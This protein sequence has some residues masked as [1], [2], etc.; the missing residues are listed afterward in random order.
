M[1]HIMSL[2]GRVAVRRAR[3]AALLCV[4]FLIV[5]EW[6]M[7]VE[8]AAAGPQGC[9]PE[10]SC[11]NQLSK[12]VC[13]RRGLIRV[14]PGIPSNTRHLNLMENSIEAIQADSFRNLHHLEVLQLGRNAIRQIE[15][16][17]FNG[18]TSLNT[19]ELFDNRLTVV[20]SGA[21]E[22][23]SKLRELWLRN[24]PIESIPSYAFNR[25]PSLMRLD[26]GELRKLEYISDGAFEGLH[27]LKYLNLGMC[28]IRGEMPNLSPLLGLEELEISENLFPE[29]KPGSF[30]GLRS[31]KKLWIM[32]SQIGL[33]ERNAFDELMSLVEL[34]LAHNNLS[35]LPHDLFTPLRYLVELH[36]HHN[37]WNCGC[38][39]LWLSRWLREYIPTNS[40]CCGRCHAPAHMRGRQLV[41][42]DRGD[43]GALQ[44]SAP[45]IADAPRDLNISAE[46]VAELRCRT[47]AMSAVR[48]LLPNGTILTH[49]SKHPRISVLNDGTLNFSNVLV[50]DTG[51]HTCMVSNAAGNS[52]ASAYLNVSAAELNTSNLSYFS[53]VTVEVLGPTSEM[54]KPKTTT[55]STT[56]A[57]TGVGTTTTTTSPSVYQPVFISTPTVLLQSTDS[58]PS[59][60]V[61]VPNS[62][63]TTGRPPNP[64]GTSLDE[65]MKTTKIIIGCF[66]A[67]TLLAAIMLIAFYKL[68][69]RHQKRST[70]AADKTV[71][72]VHVEQEEL[73]PPASSSARG[74]GSRTLPEIKDHNSIHKLDCLTHR[75]TDNSYHHTQK[76]DFMTYKPTKMDC[77]IHKHKGEYSSHKVR[78]EYNTYKPTM[79]YSTHKPTV[80]YKSLPDFRMHKQKPDHSPFQYRTH[81]PD[82][83]THRSK[84]EYSPFKDDYNTHKP[85]MD[86]S[87]HRSKTE[88]TL[89]KTT[90]DY[91]PFKKDITPFKSNYTAFKAEYRPLEVDYI[92]HKPEYSPPKPKMDYSPRK[93]DYSPHKFDY[94]L[95]PKY[96]TY[97]PAGHGAK[98]TENSIAN[99]LPRTLP[100]TITAVPEQFIIKAHA[101][102]KVQ[103]T[104][105]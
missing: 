64:S 102:E 59:R 5:Q 9:P 15:V 39:S 58:P 99:S 50:G 75:H 74:E 27:N 66:V 83:S 80:D 53:T 41:E 18:L 24:N 48:W 69:K 76:H 55:T 93:V 61:S 87:A 26:L 77:T 4:V 51:M 25:V 57:D 82:Y 70:V 10:C 8:V 7:N 89:H 91:S 85:R 38:D 35:T 40:T 22:Y 11:Y 47:A 101:K 96:N 65:V 62:K 60:P 34:N 19:L 43:N 95:K 67:V 37:P 32:N 46:R 78:P 21:F 33:I 88:H 100:S 44:C 52:N 42:L 98:W 71:E 81:N 3:K 92:T 17:A 20:P 29:I 14:P 54:P 97:K 86:Y 68:R 94:T 49:A 84:P 2:L 103:E 30:K 16:G 13:T 28:N 12:V 104:Q 1:C 90:N 73:P 45:F 56:T 23:L 105:I 31:L 36:L 63:V 72:I 6:S 79:D